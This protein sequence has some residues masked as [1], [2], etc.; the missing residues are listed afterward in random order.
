[1]KSYSSELN[2]TGSIKHCCQFQFFQHYNYGV[3]QM[4][5]MNPVHYLLQSNLHSADTFETFASVCLIEETVC[6]IQ[7]LMHLSIAT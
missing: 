1:M 7:V 5:P 2:K 6:R 3:T 4:P